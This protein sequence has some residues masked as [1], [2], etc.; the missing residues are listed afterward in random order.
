MCSVSNYVNTFQARLHLST[1]SPKP[2]P[3]WQGTPQ[4]ATQLRNRTRRSSATFSCVSWAVCWPSLN[5]EVTRQKDFK[6]A[7]HLRLLKAPQSLSKSVQDFPYLNYSL[8]VIKHKKHRKCTVSFGCSS[9]APSM[10]RSKSSLWTP[11]LALRLSGHYHPT[12][13]QHHNHDQIHGS[14]KWM[15]ITINNTST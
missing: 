9:M 3:L 8:T 1:C 14:S 6:I 10:L 5:Y 15:A 12:T 4:R 13:Y 11:Y 7:L 2:K